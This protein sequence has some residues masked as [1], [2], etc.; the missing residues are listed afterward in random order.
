MKKHDNLF[1]HNE[2]V[3]DFIFDEKVAAVFDD[4][5]HRSV[6]GYRDTIAMIG[7]VAEKFAQPHTNVYDLGCSL[8]AATLTMQQRIRQPG[9]R[10]IAVDNSEA[11]ISRCRETFSG[12]KSDVP[13]DLVRADINDVKIENASVVV[14]NFVLQFFS[15]EKRFDLL[16]R[17]AAG[18]CTDGILILS[19]KV[20]FENAGENEKQSAL[21]EEFKRLNGYTDLEISKKR[22][23][24]ENVLIPDTR[25]KHIDRL[26]MAGFSEIFVWYQCFNFISIAAVK[27]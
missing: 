7:V 5:I 10:I 26:Q 4:M 24:L 2:P 16:K 27:K 21:H 17:L 3:G 6:P 20:V 15:P 1:N 9:C 12:H 22:T 11:M 19:E 23:A 8:G 18:L 25:Q 13:V 14:L